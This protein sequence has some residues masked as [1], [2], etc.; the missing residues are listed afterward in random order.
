MTRARLPAWVAAGVALAVALSTT[1]ARS[2]TGS[3]WL[4]LLERWTLDARFGLR[5]PRPASPDIALVVFDDETARRAGTLAERRAGWAQVLRAVKQAGARVIGVDAVFDAPEHLLS[6]DLAG[7][8]RAWREAHPEAAAGDEAALLSEVAAELDGDGALEAALREAGNVVLILFQGEGES[9]EGVEAGLSR[10]RY[11][12]STPPPEPLPEEGRVV[13]SLPRFNAAAK[14]L[15][16]ATFAEDETRTLRRLLLA[17]GFRGGS[18]A[19]LVVPVAAGFLGV[20]RGQVAYLGPQQEVRLG[21]RMLALEGN[22]AWLNY[23]GPEGSYATWS[24]VDV[25]EGKLPAGALDGKAVLV[26]ITSLGFDRART[27]F[28]RMPGVEVQA[29]ALDN[30][31]HGDFLRRVPRSTDLLAALLPGLL[32]AVLFASSRVPP[33]AQVAGVLAA[34]GACWAGATWLLAARGTWVGLVGPSLGVLGAGLAGLSLSYAREA[35]QRRQLKLA[36]GRYVGEDVMAELLKDPSALALGGERR[37]LTVLF[38]DLRGFTTFSETLPPERLVAVL[39]TYLSPMTRAVLVQGGLLDKYIGDA[40]MAVFGAPLRSDAHVAKALACVVQMHAELEAL[41][42]GPLK[43]LGVQF[44]VGVGL[45]TGDMVVG[46]MGAEDRFDYTVAGDAVNL[47]SRMEGLTK[48]YGVFCLVG[49][50]TRA[51]APEGFLF[52]ALDQVQVKGK[53][54]A[55]AVWELLSGPGRALCA[56][57]RMDAWERGLAAWRAGRL[58]EAREAFGAFAQANPEDAAVQLYLERLAALPP[59]APPG[60]SPVTVFTSK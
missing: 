43:A 1:L 21:E 44:Q 42:A 41:N 58:P 36:F 56:Y 22:G 48:A 9:P 30:L 45:N 15:G 16:F 40:V 11:A 29:T 39:N 50:A 49:D 10:A 12:Q 60:F 37:R 52:R 47:A 34:L 18:Y 53:H 2:E 20:G 3:G 51:G 54:T 6:P 59:E 5:G 27:P 28:Q 32:V 19:P 7:R 24:A 46:N 17:R 38:S 26:G 25:V 33:A 14:G 55:V 23:R 13:A 8:V 35:V 31:L 57:G 4:E